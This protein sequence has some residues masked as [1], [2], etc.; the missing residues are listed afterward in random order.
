MANAKYSR[1]REAIRE[2]LAGTHS[3][4]TA[5]VVYSHIQSIYP[6]I[7]LGTVYRNLNLLVEQGDAIKLTCGDGMDHF[8]YDTS[9][10][11]HFI[12]KS[13]G[14]VLDLTMDSIN[15]INAI[16]ESSFGGKI[17]GSVTYFYGICPAC[18]SKEKKND[19]KEEE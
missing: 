7:S 16:A 14:N 17:D 4:P 19:F 1:Q 13:C 3:H 18:L 10:H 15:H 6:N 5:E 11:Y 12:C 9:E 8:D 2:Y